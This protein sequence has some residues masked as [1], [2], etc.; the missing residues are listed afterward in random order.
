MTIIQQLQE[1]RNSALRAKDMVASGF[2]SYVIS[3]ATM[4]GK[5]A[6]PPRDTTHGEVI[7]LIQKLIRTNNDEILLNQTDENRIKF[8]RFL[9]DT[10]TKLGE[11]AL[12]QAYLPVQLTED[13][14]RTVV[15]DLIT[16]SGKPLSAKLIGVIM[17]GLEASYS[18]QFDKTLASKIVKQAVSV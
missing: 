4:I 17:K 1:A 15:E 5:D 14:I 8:D 10:A 6:S 13:E 12:L 3:K 2:Y 16:I 9:A 18:G 7:A 11:N